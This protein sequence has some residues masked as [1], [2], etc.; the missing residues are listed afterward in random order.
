MFALG[1]WVQKQIPRKL[2]MTAYRGYAM[3][4]EYIVHNKTAKTITDLYLEYQARLLPR[5][6]AFASGEQPYLVVQ[7]APS[8]LWANCNSV[9][10]VVE[11]NFACLERQLQL[12]SDWLPYLEP[13]MGTGVYANAFGCEYV[14]RD[15]E[16]PAVHYRYHS[17]EEIAETP[18]PDIA[19]SP[20]MAS[21]LEIIA[22]FRELTDDQVPI[23]LTDTQS[24]NDTATLILDAAELM[25]G[26][27]VE[28]E[29]VHRFLSR[30][31]ALI[32]EFSR[33]QIEAIGT[34][35][36]ARPGHIAVSDS[37]WQGIAIS[38]DNLAVV[39]EPIGREFCLKY[40]RELADAFGGLA[41][42]SC[43]R[44]QHLMPYMA[45]MR[46]IVQ[47]D[48]PIHLDADPTPNDPEAVRD[49][50]AGSG[51]PVK[52]RGPIDVQSWLDILPRIARSD[53]RLI[54]QVDPAADLEQ[55]K[56]DYKTIDR[57]LGE[58]YV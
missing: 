4:S 14:W 3:P 55:A 6:A 2:G 29:A 42:H 25:A 18:E 10:S 51:I 35:P 19:I 43:G 45:Q 20:V 17:L 48:C 58:L 23:G 15:G 57:A 33:Q 12:G 28:P 56:R 1:Y 40:D 11:E 31:N 52:V 39:S 50:F 24:A 13:W 22:R 5:L 7:V 41:I 47:V 53:L 16:S 38:D 9:E 54:V 26:C 8:G 32:A 30:I 36:V 44:W 49:A 27:Y 21:V 34:A 37:S 46:N